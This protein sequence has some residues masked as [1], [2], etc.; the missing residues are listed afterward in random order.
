MVKRKWLVGTLAVCLVLSL[1]ACGSKKE[2]SSSSASPAASVK[3]VSSS[4]AS[5]AAP[6][7][8]EAKP[9]LK[10]L[11]VNQTEDYNTYP[12]AKVLEEKTGYK[13]QYDMLP[14]DQPQEKL[15]LVMASGESY[16]TV[17]TLGG[18]DYQALFTDYAKKG[19]LTDL[20]P[21]IDKYGPNIK[22]QISEES[23]NAGKVDGK[24]YM[25]P[26]K[27]IQYVES[28]LLIRQDWLDKLNL[29]VPT[30]LDEL[31]HVL[32]E[33]KEKDPGGNGSNNIPMTIVGDKP[34]I[35]NIVG[36]FGMPNFYN[37]VNG[38]LTP[39]PLDPAYK[40]YLSFVADLF[41][42][43]LLDK[44]FAV[45]KDATMKEKLTSGKA[46]VV[47]LTW[48]E[49]PTVADT[50]KKN[51]P[52]AKLVFIGPLKG[53][54]GK[55]GF[56]MTAGVDRITYIPKSAKNP[57]DAIKWINAKLDKDTF[58]LMAIG[59]EGKHFTVKD[60]AYFPILPIFADERNR[61]SNFLTG[62][63]EKSY[64]NYWQARVRKDARLFGAWESLNTKQSPEVKF[65]DPLGTAPYL[66]EYSK[67]NLQLNTMLNDYTIQ[68]IVSEDQG[69][70][71]DAF[72]QKY[73]SSGG[74]ASY[75]EINDW[76]TTKKK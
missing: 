67:N 57:E 13:V 20:T 7:K 50:L 24:I 9:A 53:K 35:D 29:K 28:S 2:N 73:K 51:Q 60:G 49:V 5:P 65:P 41:K 36:A 69:S 3:P 37:D 30:T 34:L 76:Y 12:V 46:G 44:E 27:T 19:A 40:N 71:L 70:N 22:A 66:Q 33:F 14:A 10:A 8:D 38:K 16:D 68:S 54:D 4:S 43:G 75:Q 1:A 25:I 42:Q 23:L 17:T 6:V 58:K 18:S 26:T 47:Q 59:E 62:I 52:D 39:R 32:K 21:L 11:Q 48:A 63:D 74:E 64:P 15:N 31:V 56:R 55:S 45:N 61:A 72:L